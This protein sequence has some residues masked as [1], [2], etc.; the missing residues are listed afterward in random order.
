[1]NATVSKIISAG[2]LR[3]LVHVHDIDVC[4]VVDNVEKFPMFSGMFNWF[5]SSFPG[6]VQ[7]CPY[8]VRKPDKI[9]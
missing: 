6:M 2:N 8:K 1:M 4:Q 5:N 9:L 3:Q 7:K